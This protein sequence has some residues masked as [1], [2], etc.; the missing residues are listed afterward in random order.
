MQER[1]ELLLAAAAGSPLRKPC[2]MLPFSSAQLALRAARAPAPL[3]KFSYCRQ[4]ASHAAGSKLKER[5]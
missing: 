3:A 1:R 2:R 5:R 4:P